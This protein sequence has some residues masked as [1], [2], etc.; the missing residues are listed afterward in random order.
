MSK[1]CKT[2]QV[3]IKRKGSKKVIASFKAR[4]GPGCKPKKR[5]KTAANKKIAQMGRKC[6]KKGRVGSKANIACLRAEA[7]RLFK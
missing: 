2:K 4:V 6:A 3:H 1:T 7:K 5:R